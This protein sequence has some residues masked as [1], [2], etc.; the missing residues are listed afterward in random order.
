M[1]PPITALSAAEPGVPRRDAADLNAAQDDG[2]ASPPGEGGGEAPPR[3][4]PP[5]VCGGV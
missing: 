5:R 3:V 1:N 2:H 4:P